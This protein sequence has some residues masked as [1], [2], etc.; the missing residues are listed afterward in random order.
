MPHDFD[1]KFVDEDFSRM[2]VITAEWTTKTG[3]RVEGVLQLVGWHR[4]PMSGVADV[5]NRQ[6]NPPKV[7][8]SPRRGPKG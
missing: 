4:P 1:V 5:I 2:N 3:E 6:K 7:T 8:V